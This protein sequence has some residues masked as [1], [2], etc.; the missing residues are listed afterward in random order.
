MHSVRALCLK[1][2]H[3]LYV[4][5]L[6]GGA[7]TWRVSNGRQRSASNVVVLLGLTSVI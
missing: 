4:Q 2:A 3:S 6:G 5:K 7:Y 1:N